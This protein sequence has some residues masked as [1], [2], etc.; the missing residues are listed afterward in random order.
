MLTSNPFAL[1]AELVSPV[2]MQVYI[3]L[4]ALA[5]ALGTLVDLRHKRSA[6][7]F[8]LR[9]AKGRAAAQR[10]FGATEI[11]S[12]AI[13]TM[14][15]EMAASGAFCK[16]K[17]RVAHLLMSY[18]FAIYLATTVAMAFVRPMAERTSAVLAGLWTVGALMVL[19]GGSWFFFRLRVDVSHERHPPL[20][21]VRADLFVI[22]LLLSVAFAL[23]WHLAQAMDNAATGTW[24]LFALYIL[25]TTV[26]C[27][28]VP[29]S[30]FAH[31]F[32]KPVAAFQGRVEEAS[33]ASDLPRSA[34][35]GPVGK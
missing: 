14:G 26:L 15:S 24:L 12:L 18:G 17:T 33:G 7:Y 1:L 25:F 30:K 34:D 6:R 31:M 21:L 10:N 13:R 9:R 19:I 23:L 3:V 32:Y 4:M 29:W 8:G 11:V 28:S 20:R 2:V 5:V 16:W 27:V 22:S 35:A